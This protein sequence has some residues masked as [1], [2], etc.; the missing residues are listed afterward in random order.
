MNLQ[1]LGTNS[2][3]GTNLNIQGQIW[4]TEGWVWKMNDKKNESIES[5]RTEF[6]WFKDEGT[7]SV[8]KLGMG[9]QSTQI[10]NL[11]LHRKLKKGLQSHLCF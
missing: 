5:G 1:V 7:K 6:D 10:V 3:L 8:P 11:K 4:R 2:S 9:D